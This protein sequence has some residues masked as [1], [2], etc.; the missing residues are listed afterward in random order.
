[1]ARPSIFFSLG[2]SK[3]AAF[4]TL[5]M[6][7]G[8]YL[9][10][11]GVM[12]N[13]YRQDVIANNLANAETVGFKKNLALFRERPTAAQESPEKQG[14]SN[15]LLESI[16]GGTFA[17]P[18]VVDTAPGTLEKTGIKTDAAI[19]GSG[20]FTVDDH[21]TTRLTRNGQF[22]IGTDGTLIMANGKNLPV[23]DDKGNPIKL[24]GELADS[25]TI[26]EEGI[27]SQDQTP[28]AKLGVV[29]VPDPKL[30]K[31]EGGT[32]LSYANMSEA[33]P[34]SDSKIVSEMVEGANVE[35]ATELTALMETQ[36]E[37]EA[38]ANMI[39]TQDS[40]LDKLVNIV[41]KIS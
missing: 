26:S 11:T 17:E 33:T 20:Y 23:L 16:G 35:P 10:A 1:M 19:S 39:H 3:F 13:S 28:I 24:N 22:I 7:Y 15:P 18:T 27:I 38:N 6:L 2:G 9:S 14:W 21:G 25:T 12:T 36:R 37:L 4:W 30:L 31:N 5:L 32:L 34:S 29:D 8:L 41:G 40:T